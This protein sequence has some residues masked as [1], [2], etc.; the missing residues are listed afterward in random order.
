[1]FTRFLSPV[2]SQLLADF[3][4]VYLTGPRQSGKST[5]AKQVAGEL[6]MRYV[7]LDNQAVLAAAD[8]D[9]HGFVEAFDAEKIVLDEFQYS[10]G[11]IPALKEASDRLTKKQRG[12]FLLTGSADIFRSA[13]TQEALPGHMARLELLPLSIT[14]IT[15]QTRNLVDYLV[16]GQFSPTRLPK[17]S[18]SQLASWII[19]GGY[20]ELQELGPRAKSVWFQSYLQGR[21]L[22]DFATLYTARG[23]Y[24]SRLV[25]L[26]A[27]L[28]GLS[29]NLLKYASVSNALM[30]DDKLVKAYIEVLELMFIVRRMPAYVKNAAKRLAVNM[31][32]LHFVDTGLA[33]HLLGLRTEEK[34]LDSQFYGG[35]LEN[36]VYMEICKHVQSS[37]HE[38]A[39]YHFR[40]KQKNEVDIVL[41]QGD[42][43]II[44]IEIKA[45]AS[46]NT[47]DFKGLNKL[48]ELAGKKFLRGVLFYSGNEVLPFNQEGIPCFALPLSLLV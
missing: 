40:D 13:L 34:L 2:V 39:L 38:I 47:Q 19:T 36:L 6:G 3:R 15:G 43:A 42:G 14:E 25:A 11:L 48:A 37:A 8:N 44:G 9:P 1:M 22:K 23:D 30:L 21:L 46:V 5:L 20:P 29:G 4:I 24:H 31:P 32:K 18:R 26:V 28:A 16:A 12:K 10:P 41:E 33:C 27:Y 45:S 7:T 35:L 17:V